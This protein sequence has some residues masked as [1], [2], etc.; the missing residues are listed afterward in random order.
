MAEEKRCNSSADAV[1][2]E[3]SEDS[4]CSHC[5]GS[6]IFVVRR[7]LRAGR[8]CFE[9]RFALTKASVVE[10]IKC[11][12]MSCNNEDFFSPGG[13]KA[14]Q[15]GGMMV[16]SEYRRSASSGASTVSQAA[17]YIVTPLRWI[18]CSAGI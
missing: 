18:S 8:N 6:G 5:S 9:D 1:S 3:T 2:V 14:Q 11:R 15:I 16:D 13:R 17:R 12:T 7:L 10:L 4:P